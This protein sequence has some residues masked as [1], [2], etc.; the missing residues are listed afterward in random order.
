M[1]GALMIKKIEQDNP[2]ELLVGIVEENRDKDKNALFEIFRREVLKSHSL[3]RAVQWYFFIN[4][5]EYQE[6]SRHQ[7]SGA[8]QPSVVTPSER[9]ERRIIQD[10]IVESIKQ[11][12]VMLDLLM[13]NEKLMRDCT[14]AEMAMF[15]SRY[16]KIAERIGKKAK[17]GDAL[18]EDQLRMLMK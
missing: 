1:R 12:I 11:Q 7:S 13:P 5:Y 16:Q 10:Q 6:T 17:V 9:L 8:R 2:R 3:L 14:G 18:T 15:G 4:M